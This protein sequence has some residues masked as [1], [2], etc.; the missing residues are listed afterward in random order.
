MAEPEGLRARCWVLH[1]FDVARAIALPA[2]R[3]VLP[4]REVADT[5]R[6]QWPHLFGLDQRPLV[7][8]LPPIAIPIGGHDVAFQP[9]AIIYDFGN[10]SVALQCDVH[11]GPEG[12]REFAIALQK[13]DALEATARDVVARLVEKAGTAIIDPR[14][15]DDL[16]VFT[17]LQVDE[18]P[19]PAALGWLIERRR[20]LA[21]VLRGSNDAFSDEEV[22][23]AT[24]KRIS[25]AVDDV[26]V[27]DSDAALIID[28]EYDDTLAVL[29]Y[30]NCEHLALRALDDDLDR[31]VEDATRLGR[32]RAGRW[33]TLLSPWG[34]E[35]KRLTQLTF[36]ASAELEAAENAIKLTDDAYLARVYRLAVDRFH[37][38]PFHEGITRKLST[39][40][41]VQ[42]TFIEEAST[43]RSEMLE[44][45]IIILITIEI[46]K[47]LG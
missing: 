21:Q 34:K 14:P 25:Y 15:L 19:G 1:A 35:V 9:R 29:D 40:W 41:N 39:L 47:A 11:G 36:D 13:D 2:C 18:V 27:I 8:P 33:R 22:D 30:A 45:I 28:K 6:P 32:T 37:L 44:W 16:E 42:K 3:E 26:V 12:W 43:R 24:G 31:A 7:W 23:D 5:R 20:L 17:V 38:R 10:V 46:V 4:T